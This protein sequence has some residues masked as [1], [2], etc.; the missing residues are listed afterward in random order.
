[1]D[2]ILKDASYGDPSTT[3][4]VI[5]IDEAGRGCMAGPVSVA[6]ACFRV[7]PDKVSFLACDSK[8]LREKVREETMEKICSLLRSAPSNIFETACS[9]DSPTSCTILPS[10]ATL[11][12]L[13]EVLVDATVINRINILNASLEGMSLV[14]S[15]LVQKLQAAGVDIAAANSVILIDG[16]RVPWHF[17][18]SDKRADIEKKALKNCNRSAIGADHANIQGFRCH[19]VTHGDQF[20]LSVATASIVAKVIR[21]M[22]AVQVMDTEYPVYGF[23]RHKGYCTAEH[24]RLLKKHG[25]CDYHRLEYAPVRTLLGSKREPTRTT[26]RSGPKITAKR[27]KSDPSHCS[28]PLYPLMDAPCL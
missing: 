9:N 23:A 5:G 3:R 14:C 26:R 21:D 11:I 24:C 25:P 22:Y 7:S 2:C 28:A 4:Y 17:Q 16:N 20:L 27:N 13:C 8:A 15:E 10:S 12:G 1:M 6:A 19:A 18:T